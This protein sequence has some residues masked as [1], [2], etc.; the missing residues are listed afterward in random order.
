LPPEREHAA[1]KEF[2]AIDGE[3]KT[4]CPEDDET[5]PGYSGNAREGAKAVDAALGRG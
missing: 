3:A 5:S 1:V 2:A 4:V